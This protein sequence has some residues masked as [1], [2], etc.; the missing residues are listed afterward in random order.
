M[1]NSNFFIKIILPVFFIATSLIAN[2]QDGNDETRVLVTVTDM[3]KELEKGASVRFKNESTKKL[4][5]EVMNK[6]LDKIDMYNMTNFKEALFQVLKSDPDL[7]TKLR[8]IVKEI[9]IEK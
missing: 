2:A 8:D 4:H 7:I 5:E 9:S 6:G 3:A 1:M